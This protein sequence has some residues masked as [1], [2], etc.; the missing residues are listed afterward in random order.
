MQPAKSMCSVSC[1]IYIFVTIKRNKRKQKNTTNAS[2][3]CTN[4]KSQ[5]DAGRGEKK[6]CV[7]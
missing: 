1:I 2:R 5:H 4:I 7:K 3:F 6:M